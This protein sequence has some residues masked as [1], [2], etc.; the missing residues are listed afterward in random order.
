MDLPAGILAHTYFNASD[1]PAAHD[2]DV[3]NRQ[4]VTV[5]WAYDNWCDRVLWMWRDSLMSGDDPWIEVISLDKLVKPDENGNVFIVEWS[6]TKDKLVKPDFRLFVQRHDLEREGFPTGEPGGPKNIVITRS[7]AELRMVT[8]GEQKNFP[9]A[10]YDHIASQTRAFGVIATP[11]GL[12]T[13]LDQVWIYRGEWHSYL[14]SQGQPV[15]LAVTPDG[16]DTPTNALRQAARLFLMA[17]TK[18]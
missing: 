3:C 13:N 8:P 1:D 4:A 2:A 16:F 9:L 5:E 15:P 10:E 6:V 14:D 17:T 11:N 7:T 12:N 18:D